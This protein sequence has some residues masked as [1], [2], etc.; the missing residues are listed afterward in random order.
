[1]KNLSVSLK[2]TGEKYFLQGI[3]SGDV[4]EI[5]STEGKL[6]NTKKATSD[7]ELIRQSG[8]LLIQVKSVKQS[9]TIR[10]FIP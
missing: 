2:K 5:F 7:C 4:I 9:Q 8:M 10:A 3:K 6:I 1:L